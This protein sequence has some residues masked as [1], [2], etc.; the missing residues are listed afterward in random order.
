[1]VHNVIEHGMMS[2]ICEAWG[3]MRKMDLGY[4]EVGDVLRDRNAS[5]ELVSMIQEE[6]PASQS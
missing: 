6:D 3:V 2:A 5:G 4:E 1:M